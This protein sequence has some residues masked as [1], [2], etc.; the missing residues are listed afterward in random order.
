[1]CGICGWY[2]K[3]K[4]IETDVIVKMNQIAKH[5]G[6]DDEGYALI[7]DEGIENLLGN[8]SI[9]LSYPQISEYTCQGTFLAFG[10]RRLSIID[11]SPQGHQPMQAEDGTL[12]VTFNGEIYNY[13]ELREEL[14]TYGYQFKSASDTEVLLNA[15]RK[16]GEDCVLHMNGMWGFAI[17]DSENS[18]IFCSRDR[19]G[20]KP[21]HYFLDDDNFI[22]ASEMKQLIQHP[23][24]PRKMNEKILATSMMWLISDFSEETLIRDIKVLRGGAIS[25]TQFLGAEI[26]E[27]LV[28][29]NI[30]MSIHEMISRE[31]KL[32]EYSKFM[33]MP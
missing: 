28:Y 7:S 15:Y 26:W 32:T 18:K 6:P 27:R 25:A 19:L 4:S 23:V 5:R 16:W 12:C 24:V 9:R 29:T 11:L 20:A 17:W 8:D 1:M 13:I 3:N 31:R 33:K 2:N 10:H 14:E 30:G 21:F 22:F